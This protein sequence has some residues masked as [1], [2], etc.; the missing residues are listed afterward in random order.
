MG[1]PLI[2]IDQHEA[3]SVVR[4]EHGKVNVLDLE[5]LHA[6]TDAFERLTDA[7]A[8]VLT[9][10]GRAFSA[11]VDLRRIL[12]EGREYTAAFLPAL[13]AIFRMIFEHLRP[14]VAAVNAHA[15][16]GGY[17]L[18]AACD[19]RLMSAGSIGLTELLVRCRS[20]LRRWRRC[21]SRPG[22]LRP[23]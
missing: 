18:V 20:R 21:A 13:S 22:P 7:G 3:V 1:G 17:V 14:V 19:W 10:A 9:G 23:A 5:L 8:V 4:M 15:I 12:D 11:G 2:S 16:A 6:L